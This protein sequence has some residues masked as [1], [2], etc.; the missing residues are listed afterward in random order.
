MGRYLVRRFLEGLLVVFLASIV[1]FLMIRLIPGDPAQQLA[2]EDAT[3]EDVERI[4]EQLGLNEPILAQYGNWIG[5]V[6]QLDFGKSFTKRVP[7]RDLIAQSLPPTIELAV[8]A[9]IWALV[10]GLPLGVA[11]ALWAKRAPD[12][13]ASVFNIFTLGIPNFVLGILLLWIFAVELDLFPVSGRV[14][15]FE[16]PIQGLHRLVLPMI[17]TGS[18]IAAVLARFVRTSVAEA[19]AQD[20]VR[21]ARAKGLRTRT[22]VLRHALRNALIPIVTIAALQIGN[23]LAGAIVV[24]IVFTRP[25]FGVL[26]IDAINGRDYLLIQAM[27]AILV[28]IFVA[29]N[30][31]ADVT[32]G[33][34]DP[35]IR[36]SGLAS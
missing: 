9:Y 36:V 35:R 12:Y 32:Y 13:G 26:I 18:V 23:L 15:V 6:V 5:G 10:I 7:V 14:N 24:E 3:P 22:V 11:A 25:G 33:Y 29:A 2:G 17:A 20:Y 27:L 30:T 8:A 4:R 16:D 28:F 1:I 19:L 34:L 21:T 31:L